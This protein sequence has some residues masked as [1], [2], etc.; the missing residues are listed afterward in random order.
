MKT[1]HG[2]I[3]RSPSGTRRR[4]IKTIDT[5]SATA[6]IRDQQ[7]VDAAAEIER[8]RAVLCQIAVWADAYPIDVFPE[9]D[10]SYY[11]NA[12]RVLEAD[13][14]TLDRLSAA[15]IRHVV[16]GIGKTAKEGLSN[17]G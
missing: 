12:R 10:E 16:A 5:E 2:R 8:L 14:M 6:R 9:P 3:N 4:A 11:A 17:A 13:G 7:V 15:A 1:A